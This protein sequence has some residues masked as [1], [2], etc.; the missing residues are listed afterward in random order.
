MINQKGWAFKDLQKLFEVGPQYYF[1]MGFVLEWIFPH[2]SQSLRLPHL[3]LHPFITRGQNLTIPLS[4]W[5]LSMQPPNPGVNGTLPG[6]G[7][8]ALL[9]L[10][11]SSSVTANVLSSFPVRLFISFCS[12][13]VSDK[14]CQATTTQEQYIFSNTSLLI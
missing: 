6:L 2:I 14:I 5:I 3:C 1:R 10:K 12:S 8:T 9:T 4:A 11:T 13:F 7:S